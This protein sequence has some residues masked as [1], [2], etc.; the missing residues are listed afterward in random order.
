MRVP[1]FLGK[2]AVHTCDSLY[3][4]RK[5]ALSLWFEREGGAG[6]VGCVGYFARVMVPNT[7]LT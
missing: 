6:W 4:Y 1:F 5:T 2:N 3:T 7:P